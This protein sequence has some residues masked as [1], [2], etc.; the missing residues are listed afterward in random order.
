MSAKFSQQFHPADPTTQRRWCVPLVVQVGRLIGKF[1]YIIG[2]GLAVLSA[3]IG[4]SFSGIFLMGFLGT[5]GR[6]AGEELAVML[7]FTVTGF[8]IGYAIAK[9]GKWL[10]QHNNSNA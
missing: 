2:W 1:L 5:G 3:V 10:I 7:F 8:A 6:E 4:L 9:L